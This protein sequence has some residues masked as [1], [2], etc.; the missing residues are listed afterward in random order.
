MLASPAYKGCY[1]QF[2]KYVDKQR[3]LRR[4]NHT[5]KYLEREAIY[6]FFY[7]YFSGVSLVPLSVTRFKY[8]RQWYADNDEH[9]HGGFIVDSPV[10]ARSLQMYAVVY[11]EKNISVTGRDRT[12]IVGP[13]EDMNAPLSDPFGHLP[14]NVVAWEDTKKPFFYFRK[15]SV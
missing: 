9:I 10:V 5:D 6:L 7:E 4:L 3:L 11:K 13:N 8:A 1:N 15:S 2:T 12:N 14:T